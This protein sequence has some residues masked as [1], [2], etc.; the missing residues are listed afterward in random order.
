MYISAFTHLPPH[1]Q[2]HRCVS[3]THLDVKLRVLVEVVEEFL[4]VAEL[5]VPL[6]RIYVSKV[7]AKRNEK[8][9]RTKETGLLPVLIQQE[10]SSERTQINISQNPDRSAA[11]SNTAETW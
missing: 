4:V 3:G 7:V 6:A 2:P 10:Q 5:S 9:R 1:P 11:N 8:N